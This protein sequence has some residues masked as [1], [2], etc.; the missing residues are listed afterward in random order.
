MGQYVCMFVFMLVFMC[1][2]SVVAT[3]PPTIFYYV[4][5]RSF[6][7]ANCR[8][9]SSASDR[10]FLCANDATIKAQV[11]ADVYRGHPDFQRRNNPAAS[12]PK[13]NGDS[14]PPYVAVSGTVG[15]YNNQ[16]HISQRFPVQA[17]GCGSGSVL[18]VTLSTLAYGTT[19]IGKMR[20][21][22][23]NE[24]GYTCDS[25]LVA[26][27]NDR[28][29]MNETTFKLWHEDDPK[30]SRRV[31]Y[32]QDLS[33]VGSQYVFDSV[34][35]GNFFDPLQ[36]SNQLSKGF[37]L[38]LMEI[39]RFSSKKYS[40]TT[41]IHTT[42]QYLGNE[43]FKFTG[44]DDVHVYINGRLAVD[45]GC[46]HGPQIA[47][48]DL[49]SFEREL[50]ITKGLIYDFD[51]F[52]AERQTQGSNYLIQTTL[53][54]TCNVI[55][56][57]LRTSGLDV[58]TAI[59]WRTSGGNTSDLE[60]KFTGGP[61]FGFISQRQAVLM[62]SG[63]SDV[64]SYMFHRSQQN[65]GS[66]FSLAFKFLM[67]SGSGNG[68][69]VLIHDRS[70]GLSDFNG[71]TGPN[72]GIKNTDRSFAIVFDMCP[73]FP[74]CTTGYPQLRVHYKKTG[75]RV[76]SVSTSTRTVFDPIIYQA[77]K[78]NTNHSVEIFYYASPDRLEVYVDNSLRLIERNF[79]MVDIIGDLNAYVG[80]AAS[81]GG[82]V[83]PTL[84]I[85]I[86][87][88]VM[89]TVKVTPRFTLLVDSLT[90]FPKAVIANGRD[91]AIFTIQTKDACQN[92]IRFGGKATEVQARLVSR[93]N[94]TML[95]GTIVDPA[96]GTYDAE[97]KTRDVANYSLHLAFGEACSWNGTGFI[98]SRECW[99]FFSV[100]AARSSP[101]S[102]FAPTS[103]GEPE[104][105]S[106]A[107][108]TGIGV[109]VGVI[110]F[111]GSVVIV[112]GVRMRNQWRRD[113]QFI[114]AGRIAA[115]E[116]SLTY[117]GDNELDAI[118]S[119]LQSTLHEI[120][121]EK[122]KKLKDADQ[123]HVIDELLR[124]Q[125]ELQEMVRRM[126]IQ[127]DGGDPDEI[128]VTGFSGIGTRVRKSFAASRMSRGQ[129]LMRQSRGVSLFN[130]NA[131]EAAAENPLFSRLKNSMRI[132]RRVSVNEVVPPPPSAVPDI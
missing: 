132:S 6:M 69:S 3:L 56:A 86:S 111:I 98:S 2:V 129:S 74:T 100:D 131:G 43:S 20:Y 30:Y 36:Y 80:F 40:F 62:I 55:T 70:L 68:F 29:V 95:V 10:D 67:P 18:P 102:T 26:G 57:D 35:T 76:N 107:A 83:V 34:N 85:R 109:A 24:E 87:D 104:G 88:V 125:G 64:A 11:V 89:K 73:N 75:D 32:K 63:V 31:G 14:T 66:G 106:T 47:T 110:S 12:S 33:L 54:E 19:G 23:S 99:T 8:S 25:S 13:N 119:R 92:L 128:P 28:N 7:P 59:D 42:F 37:P 71:G 130:S 82:N 103:F 90:D 22:K 27:N 16:Y 115:A 105:L 118:N 58:V 91:K 72:L 49:K 123:Q 38:S 41:E 117:Q 52:Q 53:S 1:Q 46:E 112:I 45:I 50:N 77:W 126:K 121:K 17:S 122:A 21:C 61:G 60:W 114:E 108:L 93:T 94:T 96:D 44:D 65:V 81:S 15:C 9:D 51:M 4:T 48:I 101:F 113:K 120:H 127:K 124:Q 39:N 84:D 97:F 5:I 78:D 79:S 116:R